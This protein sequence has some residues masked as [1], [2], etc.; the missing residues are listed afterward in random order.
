MGTTYDGTEI[1]RKVLHAIICTGERSGANHI[2]S[3]LHGSRT[4]RVLQLR[5]D[6]LRVYGVARENSRYDLKDVIKQLV[7]KGLVA[8]RTYGGYPTLYVTGRG[9]RFLKERETISFSG[10]RHSPRATSGDLHE[11]PVDRNEHTTVELSEYQRRVATL[12]DRVMDREVTLTADAAGSDRNLRYRVEAVIGALRE[13][14][15]NVLRFR[16]GL[17]G[18]SPMTLEEIGRILGVTRERI[19]QIEGKALRKLRQTKHSTPLR[20]LIE[21]NEKSEDYGTPK[22]NRPGSG[23][24]NSCREHTTVGSYEYQG[25]VTTLLSRVMGRPVSLTVDA[26]ASD[27]RLRSDVEAVLATLDDHEAAVVR[28]RFG[29]EDEIGSVLEVTRGRIL[30]IENTAL[31]KLR[32]PMRRNKL[33]AL[34]DT[35]EKPREVADEDQPRP[36]PTSGSYMH[37]IHDS[38]PRD[39]EEWSP[40]EEKQLAVLFESGRTVLE[41]VSELGRRPTSIEPRYWKFRTDAQRRRD[42]LR[43]LELVREG[44]SISEII[45]RRGISEQLVLIHLERLTAQGETFDVTHLLPPPYRYERIAQALSTGNSEYLT[46]IREKLGDG[47]SFEEIKLVKLHMRQTG[48]AR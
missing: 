35:G 10:L 40:E 46:P 1:A 6:M 31:G 41:I 17:G 25:R 29:L 43:T 23:T 21:T 3:V 28:L 34:I 37:G 36:E 11:H 26:A 20:A 16:F 12:L 4:Q 42:Y 38:Y 7:G 24:P 45:V 19:R 32:Y 33:M 39:Y 14:E 22:T 8:R 44:L 15:A 9:R 2:V 47:Y 27:D 30:Q 13:R 48:D 18:S 5:H